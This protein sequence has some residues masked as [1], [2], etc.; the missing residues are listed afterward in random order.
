MPFEKRKAANNRIV[1]RNVAREMIAEEI[2]QVGGGYDTGGFDPTSSTG[3]DRT[4]TTQRDPSTGAETRDSD[5]S[6][7]DF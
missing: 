7:W 1:I 5:I 2:D 3:G 6:V 4:T